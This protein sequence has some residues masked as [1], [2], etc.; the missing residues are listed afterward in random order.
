MMIQLVRAVMHPTLGLERMVEAKRAVR[1]RNRVTSR[2]LLP[3]KT[4][5]SMRKEAQEAKTHRELGM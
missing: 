4:S 1:D 5:R 3:A 2:P